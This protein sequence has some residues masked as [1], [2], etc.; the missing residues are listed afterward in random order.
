MTCLTS[1]QPRSACPAGGPFTYQL[2]PAVIPGLGAGLDAF[3]AW[4]GACPGIS[5]ST[6]MRRDSVSQVERSVTGMAQSVT[7]GAGVLDGRS[8]WR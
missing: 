1:C 4:P 2:V 3:T 5:G 7:G 6:V 8:A